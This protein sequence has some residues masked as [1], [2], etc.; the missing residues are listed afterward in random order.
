MWFT[1]DVLCF[2]EILIVAFEKRRPFST[3]SDPRTWLRLRQVVVKSCFYGSRWA[4]IA[5][6]S[7]SAGKN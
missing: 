3:I 7:C 6:E 4:T 2:E 5:N 1:L